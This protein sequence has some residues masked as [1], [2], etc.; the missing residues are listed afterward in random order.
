MSQQQRC[1]LLGSLPNLASLSVLLWKSLQGKHERA[2]RG[3][4]SPT[5]LDMAIPS[6]VSF[7]RDVVQVR[8]LL[9]EPFSRLFTQNLSQASSQVTADNLMC[10][11]H[12]QFSHPP[13]PHVGDAHQPSTLRGLWVPPPLKTPHL[14]LASP[15]L[16]HQLAVT[17][18]ESCPAPLG[19]RDSALREGASREPHS[20]GTEPQPARE[21]PKPGG[22]SH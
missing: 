9:A 15:L 13:R 20:Q 2:D 12:L 21:H 16:T 19:V 22:R 17:G 18:T 14:V 10:F 8:G 1:E 3:C 6:K 7:C 4:A 11:S 5:D